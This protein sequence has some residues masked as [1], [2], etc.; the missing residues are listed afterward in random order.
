YFKGDYLLLL[1]E[2]EDNRQPVGLANRSGKV[3]IP[4]EYDQLI[5]QENGSH[6]LVKREERFGILDADGKVILPV[7]FEDIILDE[8]PILTTDYKFSFPVLAKKN[9]IYQ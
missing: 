4:P 1:G 8:K 3:I 5:F 6:F 9:G 2:E 7:Q